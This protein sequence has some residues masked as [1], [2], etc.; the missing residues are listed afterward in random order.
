E[1]LFRIRKAT[2]NDIGSEFIRIGASSYTPLW[3]AHSAGRKPEKGH[4]REPEEGVPSLG[5][6][7]AAIGVAGLMGSFKRGDEILGVATAS[8][9]SGTEVSLL[10]FL[11]WKRRLD[12]PGVYSRP[13]PDTERPDRSLYDELMMG[14]VRGFESQFCP[15]DTWG[16][17]MNIARSRPIDIFGAVADF[18]TISRLYSIDWDA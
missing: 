14:Y 10:R 7:M 2:S 12:V 4:Q 13:E 9:L 5:P 11:E 8:A 15:E 1:W 18:K 17:F 3:V 16:D 6:I